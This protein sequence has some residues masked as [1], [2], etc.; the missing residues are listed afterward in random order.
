MGQPS[1][2]TVRGT[3]TPIE[4]LWVSSIS[5]GSHPKL[6]IKIN[7]PFKFFIDTGADRTILRQQVIPCDWQLIPELQLL[8]IGGTTHALI[9]KKTYRCEEPDGANGFIQPP[10]AQVTTNL[11]RRGILQALEVVLTTQPE[12]DHITTQDITCKENNTQGDPKN[13]PPNHYQY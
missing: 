9:T 12:R 4:A 6:T 10:V 1:A 2:L 3:T 8:D 13:P 7:K 11:L 5:K